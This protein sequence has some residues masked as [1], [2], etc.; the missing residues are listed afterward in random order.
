MVLL[1]VLFLED[2]TCNTFEFMVYYTILHSAEEIGVAIRGRYCLFMFILCSFCLGA[3]VL[4]L[5]SKEFG[6]EG[7]ANGLQS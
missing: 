4:S 5:G 1:Y 6:T 7:K 2:C 3:W